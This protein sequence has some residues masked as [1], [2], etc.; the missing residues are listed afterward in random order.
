MGM[1][2]S[3]TLYAPE[4]LETRDKYAYFLGGNDALVQIDTGVDNDRTLL[5][6]KDSYANCLI[7]F[8]TAHFERIYVIDLRHFN[9]GL[10]EYAKTLENITD[11]LVLYNASGFASDRYLFKLAR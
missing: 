7:P 11:S 2:K 6:A 5:I 10:V 9:F 3:D 4:K 8:L 1:K